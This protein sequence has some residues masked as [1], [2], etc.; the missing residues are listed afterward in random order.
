MSILA[1]LIDFIGTIFFIIGILFVFIGM[2]GLLRLPDAYNRLHATTKIATLGAFGVML[3]I[4]MKTGL[5]TMGLKAITV[6]IFLLL[7][8]P[9]A[10]H[11][12]ART[13][14]RC[15]IQLWNGSLV[16]E[17]ARFCECEEENVKE[18]NVKEENVKEENVKEENVKEENVKE[19]TIKA[20]T[21]DRI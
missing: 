21:E 8:A 1:T 7:T 12:I 11:M 20:A 17:Y 15:G 18:E 4:A 3:A 5:S 6:G 19:D 9:V 13:A 14:H 16:D 2:V 10:A